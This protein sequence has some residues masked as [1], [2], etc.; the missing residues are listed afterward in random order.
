LIAN[1]HQ[2]L[3][4]KRVDG[5]QIIRVMHDDDIAQLAHAVCETH[6]AWSHGFRACACLCGE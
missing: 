5:L 6:F 2:N 1:T 4:A 3:L